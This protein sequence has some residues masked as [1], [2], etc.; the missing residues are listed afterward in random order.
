MALN[1]YFYNLPLDLQEYILNIKNEE[2]RKEEEAKKEL[3]KL[4]IVSIFECQIFLKYKLE[5]PYRKFS[6]IY[7]KKNDRWDFKIIQYFKDRKFKKMKICRWYSW[8]KLEREGTKPPENMGWCCEF[9]TRSN[10]QDE[11]E[12]E[13][14]DEDETDNENESE[15]ETDDEDE[16]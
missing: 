4:L 12:E 11:E 15:E 8:G 1:N 9:L 7:L 5:N 14:E 3:S 16:K 10:F 13:E 2:E 6:K